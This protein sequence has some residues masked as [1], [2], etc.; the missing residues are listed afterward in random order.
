M[1]RRNRWL[2]LL[3][4]SLIIALALS[5]YLIGWQIEHQ[6]NAQDSPLQ[7]SSAHTPALQIRTLQRGWLSSQASSTLALPGTRLELQ[8]NIEHGPLSLSWR[9]PAL[10]ALHTVL[11]GPQ[12]RRIGIDC[13]QTSLV[14]NSLLQWD[15]S[16]Q[17]RLN[18]PYLRTTQFSLLNADSSLRLPAFS[19]SQQADAL[20]VIP[21]AV[22]F[23]LQADQVQALALFQ[24]NALRAALQMKPAEN[25]L[26]LRSQLSAGAIIWQQHN[27]GDLRLELHA[28]PLDTA[29]LL[30]LLQ[31]QQAVDQLL[32]LQNW[33][34]EKPLFRLE[35]LSLDQARLTAQGKVRLRPVE[36]WQLLPRPSLQT[37]LLALLESA[38]LE[39]RIAPELAEQLLAFWHSGEISSQAIARARQQLRAWSRAGFV[40]LRDNYLHSHLV[41]KD[42]QLFGQPP[43]RLSNQSMPTHE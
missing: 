28:E 32:A 43:T 31:Q 16:S 22:E 42:N 35:Q 7:A 25:E 30:Q 26:V 3:A 36:L 9:Q 21:T 1:T 19:Q 4:G 27:W 38:E 17:H 23:S 39:L 10:A 8:H 2:C 20:A 34:T 41:F 29:L 40:D 13:A 24:L 18:I 11:P 12:C 6:L 15:G 37:L 5:P 14:L 33:L